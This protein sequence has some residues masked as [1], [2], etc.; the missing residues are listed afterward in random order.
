MPAAPS[1]SIPAG[2]TSLDGARPLDLAECPGLLQRLA[3]VPDPRDRR[4]LRHGLVGVLAMCA[5]AVLAGARSAT[6]I[7]EWAADADQRALAALGAGRDQLTG[8]WQVPCE[9]TIRRVLMGVDADVFDTAV[10]AWCADRRRPPRPRRRRAI[11]VD[12]KTLRGS[13]A[14]GR[15]A[16]HLLAAIDHADACVL[17]QRDVDGKTNE[18]TVFQ[19]LLDDVALTE[20]VVTADALHTQRAHAEYLVSRQADYLF[21]VK[22]NQPALHDQLLGLPW[23]QI[24]VADRTREQLRGRIELRT[25]KVTTVAGLAFPHATQAVQVTRRVRKVGS[26]AWR[27]QIVYAVTS[28]TFQ[29]AAPVHLADYLRG[30]WTIEALH[31]IRDVTYSEDASTA[32]TGNLPRAMATLRNLAIGALRLTGHANIAAALRHHAR[33]TARPLITLGILPP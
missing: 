5:A 18:I 15:Q 29:T 26:R 30:H 17:A 14:D 7:A 20:V 31:H 32:R 23:R 2:L 12:G 28:L 11:A 6:A 33:D 3:M 24:P 22:A 21:V 13:G 19:P 4:G 16:V 27:T 9:A 25:L 10:G 1:S 8:R